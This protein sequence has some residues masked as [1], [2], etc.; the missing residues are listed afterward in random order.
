[1]QRSY[2]QSNN[3]GM[4]NGERSLRPQEN[5]FCLYISAGTLPAVLF[6]HP[7][8]PIVPSPQNTQQFTC[9][10]PAHNDKTHNLK[11]TPRPRRDLRPLRPPRHTADL[12][13]NVHVSL[14][15]WGSCLHLV[16][17]EKRNWRVFCSISAGGRT[18]G[19]S[20]HSMKPIVIIEY[21]GWV[22]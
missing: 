3:I 12:T 13:V 1:M 22:C 11:E 10:I 21:R 2:A 8:V 7:L 18:R 19:S 17:G 4:L 5:P 6:A 15:F 14:T 9:H 20:L 16:A